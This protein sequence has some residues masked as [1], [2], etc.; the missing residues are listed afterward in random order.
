MNL[1]PQTEDITTTKGDTIAWT[2]TLVDRDGVAIN[3][4]ALTVK[5][6]VDPRQSPT[7]DHSLLFQ[8]TGTVTSAAAGIVQFQLSDVQANQVPGTYH[9]DVEVQDA[10]LHSRTVLRGKWVIEPDITS[11]TAPPAAVHA[12]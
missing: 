6:T 12:H 3:L 7:D 5:L 11:A 1:S 8:L 9:Y 2:L 10:S 4:T